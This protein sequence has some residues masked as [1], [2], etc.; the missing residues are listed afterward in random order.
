LYA[1]FCDDK[2]GFA[3]KAICN[4]HNYR[5]NSLEF[6]CIMP[7]IIDMNISI[8]IIADYPGLSGTSL[9]ESP[10]R[11]TGMR[12]GEDRGISSGRAAHHHL[13]HVPAHAVHREAPAH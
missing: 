2:S 12:E 13:R 9:A 6:L 4:P 8:Q 11:I 1:S 3:Q 5:K 10:L 7:N